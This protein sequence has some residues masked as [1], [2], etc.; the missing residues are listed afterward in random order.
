[1][2]MNM[3]TLRGDSAPKVVLYQ[4]DVAD[5]MNPLGLL[6]AYAEKFIKP[7]VSDF[8][9]FTIGSKGMKYAP[10]PKEQVDL[11]NWLLEHTVTLLD[12]PSPKGWSSRW[13]E[14]LASEKEKGF[15]PTLPKYGFGDPTSYAL[16]QDVVEAT[17]G[18]GAVRH[19]AECSNFMFP[20]E[21][22]EEFLIVWDGFSDPPWQ[23]VGEKELRQFLMERAADGFCFP[24]NPVWPI[25]DLGWWDVVEALAKNADGKM[26]LDIWFPPESGILSKL[27]QIHAK[28]P[29]GFKTAK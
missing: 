18:C 11:I 6:V 12:K 1:M 14:V 8:D 27:G 5:P 19:G 10:L 13:L 22:D 9:T 28:Y 26:N 3:Q 29:G 21:L 2:N 17:I 16:T 4:F 24:I 15:Y 23:S 20:Q 25:R 7:V